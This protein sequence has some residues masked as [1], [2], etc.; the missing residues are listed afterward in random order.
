MNENMEIIENLK[1]QVDEVDEDIIRLMLKRKQ[2]T[3]TILDLKEKHGIAL[4]DSARETAI[5]NRLI[6]QFGNENSDLVKQIYK[7]I[8]NDSIKWHRVKFHRHQIKSI[9]NALMIRPLIIA[10]PCAVESKEQIFSIAKE[11]A[12]N[13]IKFL[14]GGAFKPRTSPD[15]FQ[16]LG[17]KGI[18][19]IREAANEYSMFVVSEVLEIDQLDRNYD[20][21]DIVQIGSRNMAAY[22]FLK[23]IGKK[24]AVDKKPI[25]LKRGFGSTVKEFLFAAR[26]IIDEGNPN[27]ILCLRGI[28]TFEQIH[29]ELRFT[30]DLATIL[31]I[32]QQSDLPVIFDPSHSTG[33]VKY[34]EQI[35][36]AA[37]G[38]GADGLLIET[39]INPE[40]A[41]S[42]KEQCIL[43]KD[44]FEILNNI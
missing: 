40:E 25:L 17:D 23:Q 9:A 34:V 28:R 43:P 21:I 6:Q 44:L 20:K 7:H 5:V 32:K 19:L 14:R 8:F 10:G 42:D 33:S 2:I 31:E 12:D 39:H 27:V 35:A 15:T 11:L 4:K 1:S 22:G 36:K 41:M 26:Y 16:G 30:P 29:S 18:E 38:L 24:T 3:S 13:G 37:L